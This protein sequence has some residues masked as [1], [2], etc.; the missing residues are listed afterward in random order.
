MFIRHIKLSAMKT[1]T[2]NFLIL[3]LLL[4]ACNRSSF[5]SSNAQLDSPS[6]QPENESLIMKEESSKQVLANLYQKMSKPTQKFEIDV[7]QDTTIYCE[8]GT[9]ITFPANSLVYEKT[10]KP[11]LGEVDVQVK[12]FYEL[13][14][15]V[16]SDL[17]TMSDGRMIETGGS[18]FV[19]A[20]SKGK[21]CKLADGA[22]IEIQFPTTEIKPG[23]ETFNGDWSKNDINWKAASEMPQPENLSL[24]EKE[25]FKKES[26]D[27]EY[28]ENRTLT[29]TERMRSWR[30]LAPEFPGGEKALLKFL[31]DSVVYPR[32]AYNQAIEGPVF[33]SFVVKKSGWV[34]EIKISTSRH[35]ILDSAA[36]DVVR[37]MP[38]WEPAVRRRKAY[39]YR[40]VLPVRFYVWSDKYNPI[41]Y[42]NEYVGSGFLTTRDDSLNFTQTSFPHKEENNAFRQKFRDKF[43]GDRIK[44]ASLR[45]V[46]NYVLRSSSLGWINCDRFYNNPNPRV[47]YKVQIDDA[48]ELDVKLVFKSV[49]A[50]L[51]GYLQKDYCA[52]VNVPI[53]EKVTVVAF[54]NV[55]GKNYV[56]IK[57]AV[58]SNE[59]LRGL[60]F[61]EVDHATLKLALS[62]LD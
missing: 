46:S 22:S 35:S 2:H 4:T 60:E 54:K 38:K 23:M 15:M 11:V 14:D 59:L 43:K 34:D 10:G 18:V 56:A 13:S 6:R 45:D 58:T 41:F 55:G 29:P 40:Y 61:K 39:D 16:L 17:N 21:K 30:D 62:C 33:V 48:E 26:S 47:V 9:V 36:L 19:E 44:D 24:A 27:L 51:S 1:H 42:L 8:E 52:F 28:E 3:L 49:Q 12:E 5:Q 53:D 31:T 50:I 25:R 20:K 37:R 7:A 32:E 57:S